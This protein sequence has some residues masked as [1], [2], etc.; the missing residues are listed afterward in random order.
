MEKYN[1]FHTDVSQGGKYFQLTFVTNEKNNFL[2]MQDLARKFV[3][4][5]DA[6]SLETR[7]VK[8]E[9]WREK[10]RLQQRVQSLFASMTYGKLGSAEVDR[11]YWL[12]KLNEI[13]GAENYVDTDSIQQDGNQTKTA[14]IDESWKEDARRR[15]EKV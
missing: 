8:L 13:F 3:D 12:M 1:E 6:P 10:L 2:A 5:E 14:F 11:Q 9:M 4:G 15:G 7:V